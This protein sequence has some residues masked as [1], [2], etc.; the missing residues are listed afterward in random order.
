MLDKHPLLIFFGVLLFIGFL[1]G[2]TL[3]ASALTIIGVF[4]LCFILVGSVMTLIYF[5]DK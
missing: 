1:A 2:K 5:T 3:L 4:A